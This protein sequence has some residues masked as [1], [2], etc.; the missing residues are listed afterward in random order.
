MYFLNCHIVS[1]DNYIVISAFQYPI[2]KLENN[3]FTY[4]MFCKLIFIN[5]KLTQ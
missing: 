3:V 2:Y 4:K 5:H 1:L